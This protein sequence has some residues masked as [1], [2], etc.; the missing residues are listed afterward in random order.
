MSLRK[1]IC[2]SL[3]LLAF[4]G[5]SGAKAAD[6][7]PPPVAETIHYALFV[8]LEAKPGKE[9]ALADFLDTGLAL[10]NRETTTPIWFALRLSPTTFGIFD[11]FASDQDRQTHLAGPIAQ[12][13]GAHAA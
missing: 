12:A 11:A 13:L 6:N 10:A 1:T 2:V 7:K 9:Q 8:R 5:V 4:T 3:A